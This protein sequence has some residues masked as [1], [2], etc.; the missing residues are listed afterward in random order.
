MTT[1]GFRGLLAGTFAMTLALAAGASQGAQAWAE[2][3]PV[4]AAPGTPGLVDHLRA[5]A[6]AVSRGLSN[7]NERASAEQRRQDCA[8][9][10]GITD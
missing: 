1:L 5:R 10:H 8:R 2:Q 3:A 6:C 9:R 4:M 7:R